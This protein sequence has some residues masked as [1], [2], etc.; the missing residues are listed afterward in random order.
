MRKF[1]VFAYNKAGRLLLE[2]LIATPIDIDEEQI[3]ISIEKE[4]NKHLHPHFTF[5]YVEEKQ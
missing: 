1:R 5:D 3:P 4:L 2:I